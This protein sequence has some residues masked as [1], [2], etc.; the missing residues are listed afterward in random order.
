MTNDPTTTFTDTTV[1]ASRTYV[2]HVTADNGG[3]TNYDVATTMSFTS[4]TAG[5]VITATPMNS[6]LDAVNKVRE[7]AGWAPVTWSNILAA[8][9]PLPAA[10]QPI[11]A[12]Q[13]M[14]C[15]AR[16]NEALQAL[17]VSVVDYTDSDLA[18]LTI[19]ASYINE[20]EARAQ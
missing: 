8:N 14:A 10:G 3:K 5:Q 12:R 15:R 19:R 4:A 18:Y 13:L 6:M 17:G 16:M 11:T 2:Y 20:V 1:V 9:D 7:A